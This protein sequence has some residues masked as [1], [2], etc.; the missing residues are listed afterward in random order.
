[1]QGII[2]R[3]VGGFY[4]V[5]TEDR[6]FQ[7]RARGIFRK[8]GT[9]PCVGDYVKIAP[10]DEEE[11]VIDE[12]LPRRNQFIRPPIA[13][14][15]C[16]VIVMAMRDPAPNLPTLDKFLV[17]A[18]KQHTEALLCLN[19]IDL[20]KESACL[21]LAAV[22]EGLYPVLP[23]SGVT[24]QGVEELA[25]ALAGKKSALAGPSGVGKS[26]LLNRLAG[27]GTMETGEVG[28]KS[29]RGKH[30]TRHVE[31]FEWAGG[32]LFD[33]PGFTS[34]DVL[35]AEEE[36]LQFLYPEIAPLVGGCRFDNCRHLTEPGCRVREAA[37]RGDIHPSRY[38][39][40]VN[41]LKEIQEKRKY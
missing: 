26:T 38:G 19:K 40:Y 41:Q 24:G 31:L 11:A 14:V 27:A 25:A 32:L 39:S 6:V 21:E 37:E 7:C 29:H 5:K 4:Y 22:Y 18:E 34:F 35:E 2:V 9:V 28:R 1:M 13:N 3:G 15:D 23:V 16:L 10:Q 12:I 33:T 30:T 20:V 17:M 36:E 8:E